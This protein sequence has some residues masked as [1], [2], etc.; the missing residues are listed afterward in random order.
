MFLAWIDE[1][2]SLHTGLH[3]RIVANETS[4]MEEMFDGHPL[5]QHKVIG[6]KAAM[7]PPPQRFGAHDCRTMGACHLE[8]LV[9]AFSKFGAGHVI[10]VPPELVVAQRLVE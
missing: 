2:A 5:D 1:V 8:Q 10:G 6:D 4:I 3:R 7:A 9:D